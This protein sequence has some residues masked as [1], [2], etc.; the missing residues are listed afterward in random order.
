MLA[1]TNKD[2][3]RIYIILSGA[4]HAAL[5]PLLYTDNLT[6]LKILL[7]CIHIT[8]SFLTFSRKFDAGLLYSYEYLYVINLPVLTVYETI[9]HKLIF[10]EKLPFLPLALTSIYCA[11]GIIYSWVVYYYMFLSSRCSDADDIKKKRQ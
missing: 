9:V 10:H 8:A 4:G 7:I 2:D 1:T 5:L 11:V 3:A 6:P